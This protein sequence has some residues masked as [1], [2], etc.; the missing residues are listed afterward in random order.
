MIRPLT[1]ISHATGLSSSLLGRHQFASIG[2]MRNRS[3]ICLALAAPVLVLTPN[4]AQTSPALRCGSCDGSNRKLTLPSAYTIPAAQLSSFPRSRGEG[5]LRQSAA[6]SLRHNSAY[7]ALRCAAQKASVRP[8]TPSYTACMLLGTDSGFRGRWAMSPSTFAGDSI[9]ASEARGWRVR[10]DLAGA[11][12]DDHPPASTSPAA[13]LELLAAA[14]RAGVVP[15]RTRPL[16]HAACQPPPGRL[17]A[18]HR[19]GDMRGHA[20]GE[21]STNDQGREIRF[22]LG[23]E[24]GEIGLGGERPLQPLPDLD[25]RRGIDRQRRPAG[26]EEPLHGDDPSRQDRTL[27]GG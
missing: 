14:A 17:L 26:H 23:R 1:E 6:A 11:A 3:R 25:H 18:R 12:R 27:L 21:A 10:V 22:L 7:S 16:G 24:P 2:S 9:V 4:A 15:V 8:T 20:R 19:V 5:R 13:V